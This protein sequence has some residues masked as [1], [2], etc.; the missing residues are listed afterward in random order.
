MLI[1]Y[2]RLLSKPV[3]SLQ[4]GAEL[5]RTKSILVDP[6]NLTVLGYELNGPLLDANPSFLRVPDIRELSNLGFIVDSSDEF[7]GLDDVIKIKEV[8]EFGFE[9]TGLQVFDD[10]KHKLGKI[11]SFTLDSDSYTVQQLI[12]RRPLLKSM[13]DTELV[14]HRSQVIEINNER[15][16]VKSGQQKET[17]AQSIREYTNPFRQTKPQAESFEGEQTYI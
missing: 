11:Q 16:I 14:I 13:S 7:V 8:Y 10:K 2:E 6:R 12:V 15:I 17:I 1:S 5:A 3:M 9:L 4:T